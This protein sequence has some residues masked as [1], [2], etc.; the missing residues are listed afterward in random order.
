MSQVAPTP[1]AL[2]PAAEALTGLDAAL[3]TVAAAHKVKAI[4]AMVFSKDLSTLW[5]HRVGSTPG[6]I[7]KVLRSKAKSFVDGKPLADPGPCTTMCCY[8]MPWCCGCTAQMAVQGAVG[9]HVDGLDAEGFV[10]S[11]A[12]AGAT[13]LKICEESLAKIGFVKGEQGRFHKAGAPTAQELER[14]D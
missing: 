14:H 2:P 12:P 10:V 7:R 11:G 3:E 13:D 6:F 4:E 5:H 8:L 9:I 1:P